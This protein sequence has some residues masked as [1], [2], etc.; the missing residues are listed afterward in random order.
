VSA[1]HGSCLR[2][3]TVLRAAGGLLTARRQVGDLGRYSSPSAKQHLCGIE[4][5]RDENSSIP[6][7]DRQCRVGLILRITL[8]VVMFSARRSEG[9][10]MVWR[11]WIQRNHE[12]LHGLGNSQWVWCAG[13]CRR[14]LWFSWPRGRVLNTHCGLRRC[15][16]DAPGYRHSL[17]KTVSL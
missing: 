12:V 17:P 8:A 1:G 13:D 3:R 16:R 2:S 9:A 4:G 15:V 7:A 14:V 5:R 11:P 6:V 10:R